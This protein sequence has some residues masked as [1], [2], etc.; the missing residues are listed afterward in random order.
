MLYLS[1]VRL[2][3]TL[4]SISLLIKLKITYDLLTINIVCFHFKS[5]L[6][7]L[8]FIA[9]GYSF[10]QKCFN[11]FLLHNFSENLLPLILLLVLFLYFLIITTL[12]HSV[13]IIRINYFSTYVINLKKRNLSI[14]SHPKTE[15]KIALP[16]ILSDIK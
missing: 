7:C 2:L 10:C 16:K 14:L 6:K 5:L 9:S 8:L 12:K 13:S 3:K 1:I 4:N 15:K 11:F